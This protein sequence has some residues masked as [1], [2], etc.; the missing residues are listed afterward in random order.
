MVS[1]TRKVVVSQ[2]EGVSSYSGCLGKAALY[3]YDI[4]G[5]TTNLFHIYV[6]QRE[7]TVSRKSSYFPKGGHSAT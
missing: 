1:Y 5:P 6:I 4:P 7:D 3:Y 2:L